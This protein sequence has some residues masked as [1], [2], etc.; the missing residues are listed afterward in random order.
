[1]CTKNWGEKIPNFDEANPQAQGDKETFLGV[2]VQ[3]TEEDENEDCPICL[4]PYKEGGPLKGTGVCKHFFHEECIKACLK[5]D[6][7]CPVCREVI[8]KTLGPCPNGYM[9]VSKDPHS[10]CQGYNDCSVIKIRYMVEP[11]V[12]GPKHPNPG[13]SFSGDYRQAFLPDNVEGRKVLELLKKAWM[14]RLTMTVGPSLSRG[15]NDVVTWNDIHHKTSLDGGPYGYP[16]NGYLQRVT[17]DMNALGIK[18]DE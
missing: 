13:K 16:D 15:V 14:M 12:Q 3:L 11:G 17:E 1:M 4:G 2:G 9:Y 10:C 18:L 6:S 7:K 5:T 8:I